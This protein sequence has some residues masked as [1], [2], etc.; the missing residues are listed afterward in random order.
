MRTHPCDYST[1]EVE[2][3]GSE[4]QSPRQLH[5]EFQTILGYRLCWGKQEKVGKNRW[6]KERGEETGSKGWRGLSVSGLGLATGKSVIH[7]YW[8]FSV[9]QGENSSP[10]PDMVVV[11]QHCGYT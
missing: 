6:K 2:A 5:S 10:K 9:L 3:G 4:V 11:A 1:Q 8:D 7:G